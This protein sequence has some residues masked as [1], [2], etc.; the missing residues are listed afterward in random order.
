MKL[1][2]HIID[3]IKEWHLKIG[4]QEESIRLYYPLD[5]VKDFFDIV[6]NEQEDAERFCKIVQNYLSEKMSEMGEVKVSLAKQ[7]FCI[8]IS[9]ELNQYIAKNIEASRF[10]QDFLEAMS[11]GEVQAVRTLFKSYAQSS[12]GDYVEKPHHGEGGIAFFFQE[13]RIDPYVYCVEQDAFGLTY[14]RFVR[15]EYEKMFLKES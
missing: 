8:E 11:T 2:E 15:T 13:E 3:T 9:K 4:Y 1:E 7:R 10:L 12:H 14:H 5:S 6:I